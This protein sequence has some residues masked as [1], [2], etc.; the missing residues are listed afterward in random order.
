MDSNNTPVQ[1]VQNSRE[2]DITTEYLKLNT[3]FG[4]EMNYKAKHVYDYLFEF[5]LKQFKPELICK[6]NV[7]KELKNLSDGLLKHQLDSREILTIFRNSGEIINISFDELIESLVEIHPFFLWSP[8]KALIKIFEEFYNNGYGVSYMSEYFKDESRIKKIIKY[9][10]QELTNINDLDVC[11]LSFLINDN[12]KHHKFVKISNRVLNDKLSCI[13]VNLWVDY[14]IEHGLENNLKGIDMEF[15][16]YLVNF[17]KLDKFWDI[18][19]SQQLNKNKLFTLNGLKEISDNELCEIF[20]GNYR[21]VPNIKNSYNVDLTEA[22][23]LICNW[24]LFNS[25]TSSRQQQ[26]KT[27]LMANLNRMNNYI[28][29]GSEK[30]YRLLNKARKTNNYERL[31]NTYV[32]NKSYYNQNNNQE[33]MTLQNTINTRMNSSK[34]DTIADAMEFVI[35][36]YIPILRNYKNSPNFNS[37]QNNLLLN[38]DVLSVVGVAEYLPNEH[39]T[40]RIVKE[41]I[42]KPAE[43]RYINLRGGDNDNTEKPKPSHEPNSVE[44]YTKELVSFQENFNRVYMLNW[45][46]ILNKLGN[47]KEQQVTNENLT[48]SII[49]KFERILVN[50]SKTTYYLSG[51]YKARDLNKEY[52]ISVGGLIKDIIELNSNILQPTLEP[53]KHIYDLCKECP[54]K[55]RAIN[56]RFMNAPKNINDYVNFTLSKVKIGSDI[57]PDEEVKLKDVCTRLHKIINDS[58]GKIFETANNSR[59]MLQ[60]YLNSRKNKNK[61]I[62][63]YF[64]TCDD[65]L[66]RLLTSYITDINDDIKLTNEFQEIVKMRLLINQESRKCYK[67][68]NNVVDT[69]LVQNRLYQLK[70][71]TLN[72]EVLHK[73]ESAYT[74][75]NNYNKEA[76]MERLMK[77]INLLVTD[78]HKFKSYFKVAKLAKK[79][80]ENVDLI[81]YIERLYKELGISPPDFN[82]GLFK[83]KLIIFLVTDMI[84]VD[85]YV[86]KEIKGGVAN[87][88]PES[89]AL[90]NMIL[91]QDSDAPHVFVQNND[92]NVLGLQTMY[93]NN[94]ATQDYYN[95]SQQ[96]YSNII[97]NINST[98]ID[99]SLTTENATTHNYESNKIPNN[100]FRKRV[101]L[102]KWDVPQTNIRG[103]DNLRI[104]GNKIAYTW[105]VD[106]LKTGTT[107]QYA[108]DPRLF[109]YGYSFR[110]RITNYY[111]MLKILPIKT[112][113]SILTP[114]IQIMDK[115]IMQ[116]FNGNLDIKNSNVALLMRGGNKDEKIKGSSY[117]DIIEPH[118]IYKTEINVE[119]TEFYLAAYHILKFYT[120]VVKELSNDARIKFFKVSILYKLKTIFGNEMKIDNEVDLQKM[121]SVFNEIWDSF[122]EVD[123]KIKTKKAL[124]LLINEI[125]SCML[126]DQSDDIMGFKTTLDDF[127]GSDM[128]TFSFDRVYGIITKSIE[129]ISNSVS[130]LSPNS[131]KIVEQTIKETTD[132]LNKSQPHLRMGILKNLFIKENNDTD[133]IYMNFCEVCISPLAI[134]VSY[135]IIIFNMFINNLSV[136]DPEP[137]K[138]NS[139]NIN[140]IHERSL[141]RFRRKYI[142]KLTI[143]NNSNIDDNTDIKDRIYYG[144][145]NG[146]G[147]NSRLLAAYPEVLISNIE[148]LKSNN[149]DKKSDFFRKLVEKIYRDYTQDVDQC[150]HNIMS[151]PGF[152]DDKLIGI[153]EN[154]HDAFKLHY[155]QAL[156]LIKNFDMKTLSNLCSFMSED[157][158]YIPQ[159]I[160]D[161]TKEIFLTTTMDLKYGFKPELIKSESKTEYFNNEDISYTKFV[162]VMLASQHSEYYLPQS[163]LQ[164]L[165][166]SPLNGVTCSSVSAMGLIKR[167][168]IQTQKEI[169]QILG[170]TPITNLIMYLSHSDLAVSKT[171]TN[172]MNTYYVNALIGIIPFILTVL[173]R[174]ALMLKDGFTYNPNYILGYSVK[175]KKIEAKTEITIL[176]SMLIKL[177][178]ELLPLSSNIQF[179]DAMD[180]K[181]PHS[182]TELFYDF[183]NCFIDVNREQTFAQYEWINSRVNTEMGINYDNYD[184]F[185]L[186][187]EKYIKPVADTHFENQFET[188]ITQMARLTLNRL[189][190]TVKY[191][192]TNSIA[193]QHHSQSIN[194]LQGGSVNKL[195][196]G[197]KGNYSVI[198]KRIATNP[199]ILSLTGHF[200][201]TETN[202]RTLF[203]KLF[204]YDFGSILYNLELSTDL[205]CIDG[206]NGNP[207]GTHLNINYGE[208]G[209]GVNNPSMLI[210]NV[211]YKV[212]DQKFT[213]ND[214]ERNSTYKHIQYLRNEF[215]QLFNVGYIH[216]TPDL[217]AD[218]TGFVNEMVKNPTDRLNR[219][220]NDANNLITIE[221]IY[222][223]ITRITQIDGINKLYFASL[224]LMI[225]DTLRYFKVIDQNIDYD[226][227]NDE[228]HSKKGSIVFNGQGNDIENTVYKSL[229]D[230]SG[231][232]NLPLKNIN[233]QKYKN[234]DDKISADLINADANTDYA[235]FKKKLVDPTT[236]YDN[237]NRQQL[238]FK[239]RELEDNDTKLD[240]TI[241]FLNGLTWNTESLKQLANHFRSGYDIGY[242]MFITTMLIL[243]HIKNDFTGIEDGVKIFSSKA[244]D[245]KFRNIEGFA[246]SYAGLL[247][248]K[249]F[250]KP[251]VTTVE[252]TVN[253]KNSLFSLYGNKTVVNSAGDIDN[254]CGMSKLFNIL[255]GD[256]YKK[257][258]NTN[259]YNLFAKTAP[260]SNLKRLGGYLS[261]YG[262][263][264]LY[265]LSH[266]FP[267]DTSKY[268]NDKKMF[269]KI[270]DYYLASR[271]MVGSNLLISTNVK[272][273]YN[274]FI[275][276][277]SY[278]MGKKLIPFCGIVN[279]HPFRPIMQTIFRQTLIKANNTIVHTT[280]T[281]HNESNLF[282]SDTQHNGRNYHAYSNIDFCPNIYDHAHHDIITGIGSHPG[283]NTGQHFFDVALNPNIEFINDMDTDQGLW[284]YHTKNRAGNASDGA[285]NTRAFG[286]N[287]N[288]GDIRDGEYSIPNL[289]IKKSKIVREMTL[290]QCG[291]LYGK[292]ETEIRNKVSTWNNYIEMCKAAY[293]VILGKGKTAQNMTKQDTLD[294]MNEELKNCEKYGL[295]PSDFV[296][297]DIPILK[298]IESPA[299]LMTNYLLSAQPLFGSYRRL[300][301]LTT[302]Q[303]DY[304]A[305][306]ATEFKIGKDTYTCFINGRPLG[307]NMDFGELKISDAKNKEDC[308]YYIC[309]L[310]GDNE[311][312]ENNPSQNGYN[313][314][315]YEYSIAKN[316]LYSKPE[317]SINKLL[318]KKLET[319]GL[320]KEVLN[321]LFVFSIDKPCHTPELEN[322][323]EKSYQDTPHHSSLISCVNLITIKNIT[324]SPELIVSF[325]KGGIQSDI[326]YRSG[327]AENA[328][329]YGYRLTHNDSITLGNDAGTTSLDLTTF[330][331][332]R[333]TA[334]IV[335]N[336]SITG[337]DDKNDDKDTE[338][339][340]I[341]MQTGA[342]IPFISEICISNLDLTKDVIKILGRDLDSQKDSS[343]NDRLHPQN[344]GGYDNKS[345]LPC[346]NNTNQVGENCISPENVR[347][348]ILYGISVGQ[349]IKTIFNNSF[350]DEIQNILTKVDKYEFNFHELK[351]MMINSYLCGL[352]VIGDLL[353]LSKWLTSSN[354]FNLS[355]DYDKYLRNEDKTWYGQI[356]KDIL[357]GSNVLSLNQYDIYSK[358]VGA[359]NEHHVEHYI[360]K[361]FDPEF[362]SDIVVKDELKVNRSVGNKSVFNNE[363]I[364]GALNSGDAHVTNE[365]L[366][367]NNGASILTDAYDQIPNQNGNA[368]NNRTLTLDKINGNTIAKE[369]LLRTADRTLVNFRAYQH[370]YGDDVIYGQEEISYSII[371]LLHSIV[372]KPS[373]DKNTQA[374]ILVEPNSSTF[375]N[376]YDQK[377]YEEN[378]SNILTDLTTINRDNGLAAA[379][380]KNH[381][382]YFAVSHDLAG[383]L[384]LPFVDDYQNYETDPL[385]FKSLNSEAN[386]SYDVLKDKYALPKV[387]TFKNMLLSQIASDNDK[388]IGFG[389]AAGNTTTPINK[390]LEKLNHMKN[391]F[392]GLMPKRE[393]NENYIEYS[394]PIF[395]YDIKKELYEYAFDE[396]DQLT[397]LQQMEYTNAKLLTNNVFT[398]LNQSLLP[399]GTK[400]NGEEIYADILN[401]INP[402]H[403]I[404]VGNMLGGYNN[405]YSSTLIGDGT[406]NLIKMYYYNNNE[407]IYKKITPG[408][409][410][411][412]GNF[413]NMIISYY[414]KRMLTL[415]PV[416]DRYLY[417][418]ILYNSALLKQFITKMVDVME[419][420][421]NNHK[422][423]DTPLARTLTYLKNVFEVFGT[424]SEKDYTKYFNINDDKYE[425]KHRPNGSM[426]VDEL[427]SKIIKPIIY[428]NIKLSPSEIS[429]ALNTIYENFKNDQLTNQDK[430][431][432][433]MFRSIGEKILELDKYII[434]IGTLARFLKTFGYH[435]NEYNTTITYSKTGTVDI[436]PI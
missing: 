136:F 364:V 217:F 271:I 339:S 358:T 435:S 33:I 225:F 187:K 378:L 112:F 54:S 406:K 300:I 159:C 3:E 417:V 197:V 76:E 185:M 309:K 190:L 95:T 220:A 366:S 236:Y 426:T 128:F 60:E 348:S 113:E 14:I 31:L 173:Y 410:E 149:D 74:E 285:Y 246:I 264:T 93:N 239:I 251:L 39:E 5:I 307:F 312:R 23:K 116:R 385:I 58:R 181:I 40:V 237:T 398:I 111:P 329:L 94:E 15:K 124:D 430:G 313:C 146:I 2:Y 43:I 288:A 183:Q 9:G 347:N 27:F 280:T 381:R 21:L 231:G 275:S 407:A 414:N 28:Q 427:K 179:K 249:L 248:N 70:D 404:I 41:Y 232:N 255:I 266:Y 148:L 161:L 370:T 67:W 337:V 416:F 22:N 152:T 88:Q 133:N 162:V 45:R 208:D 176:S 25:F 434:F 144:L 334:S 221:K 1:Y 126:F 170:D 104:P 278:H 4:Y 365:L 391:A 131:V 402:D 408:A 379:A 204:D 354:L 42:E 178:N 263:P 71:S 318:R 53:L 205:N 150:I 243:A 212:F 261:S 282:S 192:D 368:N 296:N 206:L 214:I 376:S 240:A 89:Y 158:N 56:T 362:S 273:D 140:G 238:K 382:K 411:H 19:K 35:H 301:K 13:P 57:T 359:G 424:N 147:K 46:D 30:I 199:I 195:K 260:D 420:E 99:I 388:I 226:K 233:S 123:V 145:I 6:E 345:T 292:Y 167:S 110:N 117:Y 252:N 125:N 75:F 276:F 428:Q 298:D 367:S 119:A 223:N 360:T 59:A 156:D 322:I 200:G 222:T 26:V 234:L 302:Q 11:L 91:E 245:N 86:P 143:I 374:L 106:I 134:T 155:E 352:P 168:D 277:N 61:I 387:Y 401:K 304:A 353:K 227:S 193:I 325:G 315:K 321:P 383:R 44:R 114:I 191:P 286:A 48:T 254:S 137:T 105:W 303:D 20:A 422:I 210:T 262:L 270:Y 68:L 80:I 326:L 194:L 384:I 431:K 65:E 403:N 215:K 10:H 421:L 393:I 413:T 341:L 102:L 188:L 186:Y 356:I 163:F 244:D 284:Q 64:D 274:K 142:Q 151:Y 247:A 250:D 219:F 164:T 108:T 120:L 350:V 323:S 314:S 51:V 47:I 118:E 97:N 399:I 351:A 177:Y 18:Y 328:R 349:K 259:P 98:D 69:M 29:R 371:G 138:S 85:V 139:I 308:I 294:A 73:I 342:D 268:K 49:T 109:T 202:L 267:D 230:R 331:T 32:K 38:S 72:L 272:T 129:A 169:T 160:N 8:N 216:F 419:K 12:I 346:I 242:Y 377:E 171:T 361:I 122:N 317:S 297:K 235:N 290:Y 207:L 103:V 154:F 320:Q 34:F 433:D 175:P 81:G 135:Y 375:D 340:S 257:S 213:V 363:T 389:I 17:S 52:T 283:A 87:Y 390:Q 357:V 335:D 90:L 256:K 92:S 392:G 115:Y 338:K 224:I 201:F 429:R 396:T 343:N 400:P 55:L 121:I 306:Y 180:L 84:R 369:L 293:K 269:E 423:T 291:I 174:S 395:D 182:F 372:F 157:Y 196:G 189:M 253:Y 336:K 436:T 172:L 153:K 211:L 203:E 50:C 166:N 100:I 397:S 241:E 287:A 265:S 415:K 37:L 332:I 36:Q 299:K 77:K 305:I 319:S 107:N 316:Y 380:D 279:S 83:D 412:D 281:A 258:L 184:R 409:I 7:N 218:D 228:S 330:N 66:K 344:V 355:I 127:T 82:W 333:S 386:Q 394:N 96:P 130:Q 79:C 101:K 132:K 141:D 63:D 198:I 289:F 311:L 327:N 418:E 209:N 432:K 24:K 62:D 295:K 229:L 425:A 373:F 310:L 16:N 405:I 165:E 78:P 324:S